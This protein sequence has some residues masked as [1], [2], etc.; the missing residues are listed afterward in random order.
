[1]KKLI[2]KLILAIVRFLLKAVPGYHVHLNPTRRVPPEAPQPTADLSSSS[3]LSRVFDQ[4]QEDPQFRGD[5][6]RISPGGHTE[7][8]LDRMIKAAREAHSP[9]IPPE[10]AH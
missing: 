4:M 8:D 6:P 10:S 5:K 1:M 3:S 7:D 2:K 9:E